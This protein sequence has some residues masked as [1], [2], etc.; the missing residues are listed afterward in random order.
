MSS[1]PKG[2]KA[3]RS[4]KETKRAALEKLKSRRSG[5]RGDGGGGLEDMNFD[6]EDVY[7][8]MDEDEYRDYSNRKRER[9]DFV[10]D[11]GK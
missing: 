1:S 5:R 4:S 11:D 6:E 8:R 7:D 10:V 3:K 9:E 2:Q